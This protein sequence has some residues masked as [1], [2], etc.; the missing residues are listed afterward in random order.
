[1]LEVLCPP[2]VKS[3]N[4]AVDQVY[5]EKFGALGVYGDQQ[6]F[7]APYRA[8]Q[9]AADFLK[10][11]E[12]P[13]QETVQY[14]KDICN[15]IYDTYGRFP[16]HVNSFHVPGVWLQVSHLEMEYY[17]QYFD[18]GLYHWQA[19]HREIWGPH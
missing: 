8:A 5:E 11:A 2:Y 9:S 10:I 12:R 1:M 18:P 19:R 17:E 16:A 14:V 6:V 13:P 15:Y 4:D 7:A 3:M